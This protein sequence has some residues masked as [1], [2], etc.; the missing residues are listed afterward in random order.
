MS[1][2]DAALRTGNHE[3]RHMDGYEV[4]ARFKDM[5]E[6]YENPEKLTRTL[7]MLDTGDTWYVVT[8]GVFPG[9]HIGMQRVYE[10]VRDKYNELAR[11]EKKPPVAYVHVMGVTEFLQKF[12]HEPELRKTKWRG[13]LQKRTGQ[14]K[15]R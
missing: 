15:T 5:R 11:K 6:R 2:I 10:M 9:E 8:T 4:E 7:S 12:E 13:A 3:E 1:L 14:E